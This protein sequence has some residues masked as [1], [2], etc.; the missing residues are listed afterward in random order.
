MCKVVLKPGYV[1]LPYPSWPWAHWLS[2]KL[3]TS[4]L[5]SHL[6]L[7][8]AV[9]HASIGLILPAGMICV[10]SCWTS[11]GSSMI[12]LGIQLW[13]TLL[14]WHHKGRLEKPSQER[15]SSHLHGFLFAAT[16]RPF[17]SLRSF[18][19]DLLTS[20]T[21]LRYVVFCIHFLSV[22]FAI[23][24]VALDLIYIHS[25]FYLYLYWTS[26]QKADLLYGK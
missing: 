17:N 25:G 23:A 8:L 6:S 1:S 9:W 21:F 5:F 24:S 22:L 2:R 14:M 18:L 20:C 26:A 7:L 19:S 11:P 12:E 15:T 16:Q 10:P 4:C 13:G 3:C